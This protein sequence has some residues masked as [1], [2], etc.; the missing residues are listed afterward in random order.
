M[1]RVKIKLTFLY[2]FLLFVSLYR[3][4]LSENFLFG[5]FSGLHYCLFVKV[6]YIQS[7]KAKNAKHSSRVN[8]EGIYSVH[9]RLSYNSRRII[10]CQRVFRKFFEKFFRKNSKHIDFEIS[11]HPIRKICQ[12]T[13]FRSAHY[14]SKKFINTTNYGNIANC[15]KRCKNQAAQFK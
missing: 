14:R 12:Q 8:P 7:P 5:I 11:Q 15:Q 6:L 9:K 3:S 1:I 2:P 13:A 10:G 4:I